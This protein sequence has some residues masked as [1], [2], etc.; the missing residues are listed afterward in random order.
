M[1][2][3]GRKKRK[4]RILYFL[5]RMFMVPVIS[6]GAVAHFFCSNSFLIR[7]KIKIFF[8][9]YSVRSCT[10]AETILIKKHAELYEILSTS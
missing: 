5:V 2:S 10:L 6:V 8:L 1:F 3:L 7:I 9:F 4:N